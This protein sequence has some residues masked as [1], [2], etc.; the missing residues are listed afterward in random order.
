MVIAAGAA[1]GLTL[2][3][4]IVSAHADPV[5]PSS[6]EVRSARAAVGDKS[7]QIAVVEGRLKASNV[8]L[9]A[10][11]SS[12]EVAAER[13]NLARI[14]LRERT[15]EAKAAGQRAVAARTAA[16]AASDRMGQTAAAAYRQGGSLGQLEPFL[17]SKGPQEVLER[18]AA[19]QLISGI[20][21]RI[22]DEAGAA[23][24]V[25]ADL[26]R[27]A[28]RAQAQRL[29]GAQEAES[30]R[31]SAAAL[32]DLAAA[33]SAS[34]QKTQRGMLAQL[35]T[36]RNTSFQLERQRL[37]G[38]QAEALAQE[39]AQ[40]RADARG[41]TSRDRAR[42][43]SA[44]GPG[45]GSPALSGGHVSP[46]VA[47]AS[48]QVGEPYRWGAAGP[49]SWDC[50]G[51]TMAAWRQAG[52]NLSHYTGYQW[53]ETARV[54]LADLQ[55]GDLIFFGASGPTSHHVGLY[56]GGGRMIEAPRTG[57][58]VRYASIWRSDLIAY[59]GRP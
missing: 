42:D 17:S 27:Q 11:Q 1:L 31:A 56:V 50:S 9:E 30:A 19:F 41:R 46:V 15:E 47:F 7:A 53:S 59:G 51:L 12:A 29:A 32:V 52:V 55:P 13:Y 5:Y 6:G 16:G 44:R 22:S 58:P 49:D 25:A 40:A 2:A 8:R 24:S 14:L 45:A 57:V 18:A 3:A 38:L 34:I 23:S 21:H 43:G 37:S 54:P 10:L 48:R 4:P 36:L 33:Q 28:A 26:G 20:R 35:A 39:V